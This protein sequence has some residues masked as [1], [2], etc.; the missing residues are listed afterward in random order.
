[1]VEKRQQVGL[2]AIAMASAFIHL[3]A[4]FI[5]VFHTLHLQ[6]SQAMLVNQVVAAYLSSMLNS[7]ASRRIVLDDSFEG[8]HFWSENPYPKGFYEVHMEGFAGEGGLWNR[9]QW[10]INL[11]QILNPH[12]KD[13]WISDK[14]K[15]TFRLTQAEFMWLFRRLEVHLTKQTTH[16][17]EPVPA[18]KRLC[19]ALYF[20]ATG[21]SFKSVALHFCLGRSTTSLIIHD[22]VGILC[23]EIAPELIKFPTGAKLIDARNAFLGKARDGL[24][25][26][27]GAIDGT[28][29]SIIKPNLPFADS[30]FCYKKYTAIII[31]AVVD[32][33]G[34]FI[35]YEAGRPGSA[36][37]GFTFAMSSLRRRILT[38]EWLTIPAELIAVIPD[39]ELVLDGVVIPPYIVADSA[40]ALTDKFM[41]CYNSVTTDAEMHF[42]FACINTRRVVEC[43]FGRLKSRFQVQCIFLSRSRIGMLSYFDYLKLG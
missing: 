18:K 8:R 26:C 20:L 16:L 24:Q 29:M 31:L 11:D 7:R 43:A 33:N 6:Q 4:A 35:Y 32:A 34:S 15:S 37:D 12:H 3:L 30:Y 40:F 25:G 28:F 10:D 23:M 9:A 17:R 27:V 13:Q 2:L 19:V 14:Y 5:V 41:K 21:H 22:V 36:G 42:N 39:A 1:M 38:G